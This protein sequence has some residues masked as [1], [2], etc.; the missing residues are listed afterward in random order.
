[1]IGGRT[2]GELLR[3]VFTGAFCVGLNV[4]IVTT[5]TEYA[6]LHYL[7]SLSVCFF[8]VTF[9]GFMINRGWTFRKTGGEAA[10]DFRRYL[11]VNVANMVL[12]LSLTWLCVERLGIPYPLAIV[13]ISLAFVP[14]TFLLHRGWSFGLRR[15]S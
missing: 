12:G 4:L 9:V 14:L 3:F 11:V 8:T 13:L 15:G 7:V 10:K 5:L 1:V 6:H 2:A